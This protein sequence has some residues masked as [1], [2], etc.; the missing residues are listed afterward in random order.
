[1]SAFENEDLSQLKSHIAHIEGI[2]TDN[3]HLYHNGDE[4]YN[5]EKLSDLTN[6]INLYMS[7]TN[8]DK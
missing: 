3:L 1:V 4:L 5:S 2:E 8:S 7:V 6:K